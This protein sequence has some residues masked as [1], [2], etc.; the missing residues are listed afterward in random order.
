[1]HQIQAKTLEKIYK[2]KEI[3]HNMTTRYKSISKDWLKS[4]L[5]HKRRREKKNPENPSIKGKKV[6]RDN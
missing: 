4:L 3:C 2:E 6:K 5:Q 1:M